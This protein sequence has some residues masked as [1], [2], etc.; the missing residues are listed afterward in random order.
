MLQIG[1][2]LWSNFGRGAQRNCLPSLAIMSVT[3]VN[4]Q[5]SLLEGEAS[6]ALVRKSP[7][8]NLEFSPP[9]LYQNLGSRA[10]IAVRAPLC[11]RR[12]STIYLTVDEMSPSLSD[13]YLMY[14]F[15]CWQCSRDVLN[16]W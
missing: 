4:V 14:N 1:V 10:Y 11:Y 2:L 9:L 7:E 3:D 6:P 13:V 12:I 16:R 5:A 8:P 15:P